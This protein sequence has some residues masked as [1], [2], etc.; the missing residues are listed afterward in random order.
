MENPK[1]V[2]L[3]M[4]EHKIEYLRQYLEL[5]GSESNVINTCL[6]EIKETPN[7]NNN[8]ELHLKEIE[9]KKRQLNIRNEIIAKTDMLAKYTEKMKRDKFIFDALIKECSK[10]MDKFFKLGKEYIHINKNGNAKML[11]PIISRIN[12]HKLQSDIL[13]EKEYTYTYKMLKAEL[14]RLGVIKPK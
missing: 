8:A 2:N 4:L 9:Y 10:N 1:L 14:I 7:Y 13:S 5:L 6:N 12:K 3:S 11:V